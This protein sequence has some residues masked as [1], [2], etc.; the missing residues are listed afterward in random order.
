M[1]KSLK[2]ALQSRKVIL[3]VGTCVVKYEGRASSLLGPG[4]RIVIIKK[5]RSIL[6]HRPTGYEP[7]N[8]QPPNSHID[9]KETGGDLHL[10]ITRGNEKLE[11]S[12][13]GVPEI[14]SFTLSDEASF[15]MYATESD[16]KT[17][18]LLEPSLIEEGFKPI[19]YERTVYRTG[20]LDIFG[21]DR[22]GELV[23]VELK[24][25]QATRE[26]I[27]QLKRYVESMGREFG[28]RPRAVIAAPSISRSAAALC[29]QAGVEFKCLTPRMC[30]EVLRKSKGLDSYL[31]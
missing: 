15:D 31:N 5:D 21:R 30:G 12:F 4:E 19:D 23:V 6:V 9:I 27:L 18:V 1:S 20:R 24:K 17:A 29:S 11:I 25:R 26:D 2:S 13:R 7:V 22:S 16:M 10:T 3:L 8:W 28:G 14:Y